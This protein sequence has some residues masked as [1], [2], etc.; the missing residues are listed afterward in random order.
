MNAWWGSGLCC[1]TFLDGTN[2]KVAG[3]AALYH[4]NGGQDPEQQHCIY[5]WEI[6][7]THNQIISALPCT[8]LTGFHV[9]WDQGAEP[10]F[11]VVCWE[12]FWVRDLG[13]MCTEISKTDFKSLYDELCRHRE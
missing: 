6:T 11:Q 9:Y 4:Y 5:Y 8:F 12:M 3:A 7:D 10:S 2:E 13:L 1:S